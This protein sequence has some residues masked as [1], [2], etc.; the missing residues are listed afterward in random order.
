M[1]KTENGAFVALFEPRT[2][3]QVLYLTAFVAAIALLNVIVLYGLLSL[4]A[5]VAERQP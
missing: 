3:I 2:P 5:L 4:C 1:K